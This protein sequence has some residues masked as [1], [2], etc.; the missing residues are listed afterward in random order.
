MHELVALRGQ[1][2]RVAALTQVSVDGMTVAASNMLPAGARSG[3]RAEVPR[4]V[5]PTAGGLAS[6]S[7]NVAVAKPI[8]TGRIIAA[9]RSF[10]LI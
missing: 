6:S 4:W 7:A 5:L 10:P 3:C 8:I 2:G 1:P 9:W